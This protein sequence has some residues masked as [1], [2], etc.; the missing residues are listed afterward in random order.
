LA[1]IGS[2]KNKRAALKKMV[3]EKR[4]IIKAALVDLFVFWALPPLLVLLAVLPPAADIKLCAFLPAVLK[5]RSQRA[6]LAN[7]PI[8]GN[9]LEQFRLHF[10]SP[11][12]A[13]E[14]APVLGHDG[15]ARLWSLALVVDLTIASPTAARGFEPL[16][17]SAAPPSLGSLGG[18]RP[19][20]NSI[21]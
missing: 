12:V 3:L 20:L 5:W 14:L 13:P 10:L 15:T 11:F 1:N 4:T 21:D 18:P 16:S 17:G 2:I 9:T 8:P 6:T 7:N 19:W